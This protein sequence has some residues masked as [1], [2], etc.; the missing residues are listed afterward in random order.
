MGRST[1]APKE[2]THLHIRKERRKETHLL[3]IG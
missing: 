1:N 2:I 3:T